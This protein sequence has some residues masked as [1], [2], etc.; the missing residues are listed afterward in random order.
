MKIFMKSSV[1]IGFRNLYS[2][3]MYLWREKKKYHELEWYNIRLRL[4]VSLGVCVTSFGSSDWKSVVSYP[5]CKDLSTPPFPIFNRLRLTHSNSTN[6]LLLKIT[7]VKLEI[8]HKLST[9]PQNLTTITITVSTETIALS[10][11]ALT[12]R[13][14]ITIPPPMIDMKYWRGYRH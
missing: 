7:T 3:T 11:Q 9:T 4:R 10:T 8:C 6:T 5:W 14:P 2:F 12:T 13:L 1:S